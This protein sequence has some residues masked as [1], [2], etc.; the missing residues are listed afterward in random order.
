MYQAQM[1]RPVV[2]YA[3]MGDAA[4]HLLKSFEAL[5]EADRREVLEQLL[6]RAADLPYAFPTDEEL[7][8]AADH[9][10]QE[11]DRGEAKG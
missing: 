3:R 6:R 10:F 11:L 1:Y 7:R 5:S 8:H 4:R 2:K 9:V